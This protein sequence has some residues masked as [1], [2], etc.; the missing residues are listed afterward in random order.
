MTAYWGYARLGFILALAVEPLPAAGLGW[1]ERPNVAVG[2]SPRYNR[3]YSGR[4]MAEVYAATVFEKA[5][6]VMLEMG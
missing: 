1:T 4:L 5:I 3:P 2:A 6:S